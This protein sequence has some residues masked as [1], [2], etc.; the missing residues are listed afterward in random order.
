MPLS[1]IES[2][3]S[4]RRKFM[5]RSMKILALMLC[6]GA[7]ILLGGCQQ[8]PEE[9]TAPTT[10]ITEPPLTAAEKYDLA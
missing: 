3:Q 2:M 7:L 4:V 1:D 8:S 6:A 9:T 10:I 5:K